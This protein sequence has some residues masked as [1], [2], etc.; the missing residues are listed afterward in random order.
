M[1]L[2]LVNW[3]SPQTIADHIA[4]HQVFFNSFSWLDSADNQGYSII[5][6]DASHD[7]TFASHEGEKFKEFLKRLQIPYSH[8]FPDTACLASSSDLITFLTQVMTHD[9][10]SKSLLWVGRCDY[11]ATHFNPLFKDIKICLPESPLAHFW[12]YE[13]FYIWDHAQCKLYIYASDLSSQNRLFLLLEEARTKESAH[14]PDTSQSYM[15]SIDK[16]PTLEREE[17]DFNFIRTSLDQGAFYQINYT[18]EFSGQLLQPPL[19]IYKKLRQYCKHPMM[20]FMNHPDKVILSASP[21]SFFKIEGCTITTEPIKGTAKRHPNP[22]DDLTIQKKLFEGQKENAELFMITDLLRNDLGRLCKAPTVT[23][24]L[25]ISLQSF[26]DYHHL[27]SRISGE[28]LPQTTL[29]DVF[30]ALF[31]GGSI[32]GAPKKKVIESIAKLEKRPRGAYTGMVGYFIAGRA[33]FNIAIR[34]WDCKDDVFCFGVGGGVVHDST[35]EGEFQELLTKAQ[36]LL[37]FSQN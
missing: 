30:V 12:G 15:F 18:Q 32:T 28:L 14:L 7:A 26:A 22:Q 29:W 6:F 8:P 17:Q 36:T 23:P 27:V 21:E 35:P 20:A 33:H 37:K 3:L 11:E 16:R 25:L 9:P 4:R 13:N 34:T 19:Q 31:P 1:T 5:A 24:E 2:L 10:A